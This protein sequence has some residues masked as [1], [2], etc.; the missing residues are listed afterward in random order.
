M[1]NAVKKGAGWNEFFVE[2]VDETLKQIFKEDGA[3][4]IYEFL[5]NHSCLKLEEISDKP[6]VFSAS[7]ERL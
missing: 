7:L 2:A 4:V 6:E 1:I 3:K 5:E